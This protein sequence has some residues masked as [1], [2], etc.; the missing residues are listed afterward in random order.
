MPTRTDEGP[1]F[2]QDRAAEVS[3]RRRDEVRN[4]EP[5]PSQERRED[6]ADLSWMDDPDI[7]THGSE[8]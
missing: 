8:R 5:Q 4:I 2:E 3:R 7:N 6:D 1:L